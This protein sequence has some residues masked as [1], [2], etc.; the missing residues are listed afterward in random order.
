MISIETIHDY[1]MYFFQKRCL[2]HILFIILCIKHFMGAEI[3]WADIKKKEARGL[4]DLDLGEVQEIEGNDIILEKGIID[5][6]FYRIPKNLAINFDG[7]VLN[8]N[9]SEENLKKYEV[10][11]I[12]PSVTEQLES[13]TE[14]D[15]GGGS[16]GGI[17]VEEKET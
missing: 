3:N 9:V 2:V 12:A 15:A 14:I 5:K 7:H 13:T 1:P 11:S 10:E 6:T 4:E 16:G 17:Q 8:L